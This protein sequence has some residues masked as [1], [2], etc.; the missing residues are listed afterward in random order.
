M[1][2]V[3]PQNVKSLKDEFDLEKSKNIPAFIIEEFNKLIIEN[4]SGYRTVVFQDKLVENVL[5]N[6]PEIEKSEIF[7]K[8][9]L[10]VEPLYRNQGWVVNYCSNSMDR[11]YFEF[12][13]K[14]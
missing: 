2:P 1:L 4:Y 10:N 6:N 8:N 13:L 12:I 9:W 14:N 11:N 5:K 7:I 3:K